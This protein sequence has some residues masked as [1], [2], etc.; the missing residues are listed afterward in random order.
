MIWKAGLLSSLLLAS[1]NAIIGAD[2]VKL[3][4]S[5]C[6]LDSG[7]P[8]NCASEFPSTSV[9]FLTLSRGDAGAAGTETTA[10]VQIDDEKGKLEAQALQACNNYNN[11]V[12]SADTYR[13]QSQPLEEQLGQVAPLFDGIR[14][15][16]SEQKR[17][18][19]V[20][21]AYQTFVPTERRT[22]LVLEFAIY[23]QRPNESGFFPIGQNASLPTNAHLYFTI[24][25]SRAGYVY[26]FQRAPG[27]SI[28]TLFP[29]SVHIALANPVPSGQTLRIPDGGATF[30]VNEQDIGTESVYIVTSLDAVPSLQTAVERLN[31]D[32]G[33][34]T[35]L[36]SL[37]EVKSEKDP[38][39]SRALEYSPDP[40]KCSRSRGL[41]YE[42]VS[43]DASFRSR[44]EAADSMIVQVFTF[45]HTAQ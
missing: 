32:A 17:I 12:I 5:Q 34:D 35:T 37:A 42:G 21:T 3:R 11:C 41:E 44:T 26:L 22:E 33:V 19:A 20:S 38:S 39:C 8:L 4:S 24:R 15:S 29:D 40:T 28:V 6:S 18:V 9:Q 31:S 43:S 1:C 14:Q 30:R 13:Q 25:L 2:E 16:D 36:A 7:V 10:L 45:Q 27:G 23:A